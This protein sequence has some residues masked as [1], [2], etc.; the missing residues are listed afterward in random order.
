[1]LSTGIGLAIWLLGSWR[2]DR[3]KCKIGYRAWVLFEKRRSIHGNFDKVAYLGLARKASKAGRKGGLDMVECRPCEFGDGAGERDV[4]N[5]IV[6]RL[7]DGV[8]G[9]LELERVLETPRTH[10]KA[11]L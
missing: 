4:G 10:Y 2:L 9:N 6:G 7:T 8:E 11:R 3:Q 5:G 1:M